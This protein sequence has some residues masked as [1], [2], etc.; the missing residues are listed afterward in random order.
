MQNEKQRLE[1]DVYRWRGEGAW[2]QSSWL[3][4]AFLVVRW[5][6]CDVV[7]LLWLDVHVEV[8][9]FGGRKATW[10]LV[11]QVLALVSS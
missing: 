4:V 9:R 6:E 1:M 5:W 11:Y 2:Q 3:K 7:M 8:A 10:S